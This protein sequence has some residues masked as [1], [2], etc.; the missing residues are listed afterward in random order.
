MADFEGGRIQFGCGCA[1]AAAS[2]RCLSLT[3][4]YRDAFG[5]GTRSGINRA[6]IDTLATERI[7]AIALGY[8]DHDDSIAP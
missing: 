4:G 1:P 5:M 8:E 7:V 2:I 6:L 3:N